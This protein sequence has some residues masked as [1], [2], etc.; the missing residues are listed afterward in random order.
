M[1]EDMFSVQN[2]KSSNLVVDPNNF[3]KN[4]PAI[5]DDEDPNTPHTSHWPLS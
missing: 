5:L 1:T 3:E 2:P 4:E